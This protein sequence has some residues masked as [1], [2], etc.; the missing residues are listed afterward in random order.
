MKVLVAP[1]S[2]GDHL[3]SHQAALM[4]ASGWR[5]WATADEATLCPL[6]DGATGLLDCVGS[7]AAASRHSLTI[8]SYPSVELDVA[9]VSRDGRITVFIE[10]DALLAQV[11]NDAGVARSSAVLGAALARVVTLRPATVVLGIGQRA[12][13][14]AGIGLIAAYAQE[15]GVELPS[16]VSRVLNED[17]ESVLPTEADLG[18]LARARS[19][20]FAYE[21]V[22]VTPF[23]VELTG[24]HGLDAPRFFGGT[25]RPRSAFSGRELDDLAFWVAR[26]IATTEPSAHRSLLNDSGTEFPVD[27]LRTTLTRSYGAGAG[28]G[29]GFAMLALG[30]RILPGADFVSQFVDLTT[31]IE[32]SDLVLTGQ[33]DLGPLTLGRSVVEAVA[34]RSI[35]RATPVVA[36]S[37]NGGLSRRELSGTGVSAAF[38]ITPELCE[39][40]ESSDVES[41]RALVTRVARTWSQ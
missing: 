3:A 16:R 21:L 29:L 9:A 18:F 33:R 39:A 37:V 41:L 38:S 13:A 14:D 1:G 22:A 25:H 30:S 34:V 40:A 12:V 7:T 24:P 20:A 31:H 11:S 32:N 17:A 28:A 35:P 8:P 5:D 2:F 6:S 19:H 23:E 10:S 26:T 15:S 27:A 4:I 36:L